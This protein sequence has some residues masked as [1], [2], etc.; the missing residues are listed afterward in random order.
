MT[1]HEL[2]ELIPDL[3]PRVH[4]RNDRKFVCVDRWN[5]TG[6]GVVI[7]LLNEEGRVYLSDLGSI[8]FQIR[9]HGMRGR[10]STCP[11]LKMEI[12]TETAAIVAE[13]FA[14]L[15]VKLYDALA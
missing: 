11:E 10:Y 5:R 3:K 9:C 15:C 1:I 8:G 2:A 12:T 7:Y 6:D 13:A 4:E 14:D